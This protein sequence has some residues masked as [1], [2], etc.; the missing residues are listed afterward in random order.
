MSMSDPIADLLSRLRNAH[1]VGHHRVEAPYSKMKEGILN[2]LLNEGY[3]KSFEV[4]ELRPNVKT[5][6]IHLKY[7]DGMPVIR[8]ITRVSKPG[9]RIYKGVQ[10]IPRIYNGLGIAIM[11]TSKGIVS[12]KDARQTNLGGE[13]LCRVF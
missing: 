2:V 4:T 7:F 1:N 6:T 10:D 11:S 3:I 12:D 5:I 13:V 8:E 9:R